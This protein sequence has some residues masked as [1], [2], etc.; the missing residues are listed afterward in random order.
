[1]I[2][3]VAEDRR[4]AAL[5]AVAI[6]LQVLEAGIPS[7]I[8]GVK[9]GLANIVTLVALL[10]LGWR[11]ALALTLV[12]VVAA[13]L[14]LGTFLSPAFWLSLVGGMTALVV[15]WPLRPL[16]PRQLSALGLAIPAALAHVTGQFL[17]A[18]SII[19]PHPQ[20][21]WLLPPLLLSALATGIVTGLLATAVL[22]DPQL[23]QPNG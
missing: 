17:F 6:A 19:I 3:V 14:L 13:G 18:W 1:M 23:R 2:P 22:T 7:P 9:P 15:L 20:L 4:I 10:M 16:Y 21:P 11:A 5:A 12:R 8:P